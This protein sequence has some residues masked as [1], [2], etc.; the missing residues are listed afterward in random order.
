MQYD[1]TYKVSRITTSFRANI[2][3][4]S[5]VQGPPGPPG[6]QGDTGPGGPSGKRGLTG[7][8]GPPGP[9]GNPGPAGSP[10]STGPPGPT[11]AGVV[12]VR[13]GR[14]TCPS[15]PGTRLVYKGRAGGSHYQNSGGGANRLCLPENPQ[16]LD[17]QSGFQGTG[18]MH[19]AEYESYGSRA[20]GNQPFRSMHNR[21]V[22]CAVCSVS[23]R[24]MLLMIPA[25]ISCPSS[26]T[27]EYYG[28]LVA[29]RWDRYRSSY[30]C[31]DK[32]PEAIP[33]NT[34][35]QDGALFYHVETTCNGLSCSS[36]QYVEGREI[37]CTV[38]T[39]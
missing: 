3:F 14:T 1:H 10:S 32:N 15:T 4:D 34:E 6:P 21:N 23:T 12:Y 27:R 22:P 17:Y 24:E 33:G 28:Y 39:K 20:L 38:C 8:T 11:A 35:N 36:S 7:H 16:Y 30:D 37:T 31:V 13:W 26:W 19:G 9:Q 2:P 25:R 5:D 18:Y 29:E